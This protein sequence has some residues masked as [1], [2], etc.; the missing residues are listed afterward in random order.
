[1]GQAQSPTSGAKCRNQIKNWITNPRLGRLSEGNECQLNNNGYYQYKC[2]LTTKY[3]I[4]EKVQY[5]LKDKKRP[6][7]LTI[8]CDLIF[9]QFEACF[10]YEIH[11]TL[12]CISM[13][14]SLVFRLCSQDA[15]HDTDRAG[16]D[17]Q[18]HLLKH[19]LTW[20]HQHVD[21]DNIKIIDMSFHKKNFN[22]LNAKFTKW[23]NTLKHWIG[24]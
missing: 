17:K 13:T 15:C 24:T 10:F 21:L 6:F 7:T 11:M 18:P 8:R 4:R 22:P 23:S 20:N 3:Q 12:L 16:K 5:I 2:K 14:S 9:V 1:M 19:I